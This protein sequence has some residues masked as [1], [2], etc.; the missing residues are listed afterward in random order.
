MVAFNFGITGGGGTRETVETGSRRTD[1]MLGVSCGAAQ[2]NICRDLGDISL[3]GLPKPYL[4]CLRGQNA[5][6]PQIRRSG[7]LGLVIS[8]K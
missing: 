8:D 7:D 6:T 1:T 3:R 4:R 5:K 2:A